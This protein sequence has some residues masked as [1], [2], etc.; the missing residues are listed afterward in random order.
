MAVT[1][2]LEESVSDSKLHKDST[3]K[4]ELRPLSAV[5]FSKSDHGPG[6][7]ELRIRFS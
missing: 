7:L 2:E 1:M 5:S 4:K 3:A 6:S